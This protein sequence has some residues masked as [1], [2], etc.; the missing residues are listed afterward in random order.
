MRPGGDTAAVPLPL[1]AELNIGIRRGVVPNA[2]AL[3]GVMT[4]WRRGV[5]RTDAMWLE[6]APARMLMAD[7][8]VGRALAADSVS[9]D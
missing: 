7:C 1:T 3:L 4:A 2:G 6:L 8:T 9:S 5:I